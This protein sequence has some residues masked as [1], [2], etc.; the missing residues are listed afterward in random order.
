MKLI[1]CAVFLGFAFSSCGQ[2]VPASEIPSV[3]LNAL[4]T[5]YAGSSDPDWEKNG[6][7]YEAEFK[8]KGSELEVLLDSSG[9]VLM[10]KKEIAEKDIPATVMAAIKEN[11]REYGID[12]A[13]LLEKAGITFYQVELEAGSKKDLKLVFNANGAE[14]KGVTYWN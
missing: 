1:I 8:Y 7:N 4:T 2:K 12:E 9:T 3:V 13:E 6:N 11:Y 14:E 5:K 10:Q